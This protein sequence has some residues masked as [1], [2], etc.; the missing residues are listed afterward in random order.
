MWFF[1][2]FWE[3]NRNEHL[4]EELEVLPRT[5][6]GLGHRKLLG[7]ETKYCT[8]SRTEKVCW[9]EDSGSENKSFISLPAPLSLGLSRTLENQAQKELVSEQR[10]FYQFGFILFKKG[11]FLNEET[12]FI[13]EVLLSEC[14][15]GQKVEYSKAWYNCL[16]GNKHLYL[17]ICCLWYMQRRDCK[18]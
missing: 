4:T 8:T 18:I 3:N 16:W 6:W 1:H 15:H 9:V 10:N 12:V 14:D 7:K 17:I 5:Q 2:D 11:F 13:Y